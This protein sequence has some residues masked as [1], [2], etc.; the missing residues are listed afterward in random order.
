MTISVAD[1]K[2]KIDNK[3]KIK[4]LDCSSYESRDATIK[5]PW[6]SFLEKHIPGAQFLHY[7]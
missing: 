2:A 4:I 3:D 6:D 5:N 1:L 7:D